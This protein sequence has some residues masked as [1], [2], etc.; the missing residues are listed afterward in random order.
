[1]NRR[2]QQKLPTL[3]D[4]R[5]CAPS[6]M[7]NTQKKMQVKFAPSSF[8]NT[9]SRHRRLRAETCSKNRTVHN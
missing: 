5:S 2:E 3:R 6:A 1:M 8:S 9:Q 7:Y 4:W